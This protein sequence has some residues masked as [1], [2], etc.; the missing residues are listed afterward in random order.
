MSAEQH[1]HL[2]DSYWSH[3]ERLPKKEQ[4]RVSEVIRQFDLAFSFRGLPDLIKRFGPEQGLYQCILG[5]A[6][7]I[8]SLR[9]EMLGEMD[10][11]ELV[12][13]VE[14]GMGG[15][16][17]YK[18][19]LYGQA[20][21]L[22]SMYN[23]GLQFVPDSLKPRYQRESDQ[24]IKI[25]ETLSAPLQRIDFSLPPQELRGSLLAHGFHEE[26]ITLSASLLANVA[27][28]REGITSIAHL[29]KVLASNQTIRVFVGPAQTITGSPTH[30]SHHL[31]ETIFAW[32]SECLVFP[33]TKEVCIR[34]NG[35][36]GLGRDEDLLP[37]LS[38][39]QQESETFTDE[40]ALMQFVN[41]LRELE[42]Q[43]PK[44]LLDF[45][46][47]QYGGIRP[48]G[49]IDTAIVDGTLS[50]EPYISAITNLF[51]FEL[52]QLHSTPITQIEARLRNFSDL[53]QHQIAR[54][55]PKA[56]DDLVK[57]YKKLLSTEPQI[58]VKKFVSKLQTTALSLDSRFADKID[59][60]LL[61]CVAGS[62]MS[63]VGK[64]DMVGNLQMN[65]GSES[66]SLLQTL[67][68]RKTG[69]SSRAELEQFC[70]AFGK[71]ASKYSS[72]RECGMCHKPTFV[73]GKEH[74]GCD[75]CPVCEVKDDFG[76]TGAIPSE[77]G[78]DS[79]EDTADSSTALYATD[80]IGVGDALSAATSGWQQFQVAA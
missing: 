14:I 39:S 46:V 65:F 78:S 66:F 38:H 40:A 31:G 3:K 57:Q 54:N 55:E 45:L 21:D 26:E 61:D 15:S 17:R 76:I 36:F 73:W 7:N 19:D 80:T 33:D 16:L 30:W 41:I 74:G 13:L 1:H 51:S 48:A 34:Q 50:I 52:T 42:Y 72:Y 43:Q 24:A 75:V 12:T 20:R 59:F 69:I 37:Y 71:D 6:L 56:L 4:R 23:A 63:L 8:W 70:K 60:S 68:R 28:L 44:V 22:E 9:Q 29:D 53:I 64:M 25:F 11:R 77:Y 47:T 49:K 27:S 62:P 2:P 10:T 79:M 58:S 5:I 35:K 18:N 67:D 32:A